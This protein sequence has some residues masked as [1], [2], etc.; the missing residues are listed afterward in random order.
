M[1]NDY[2]Q[3]SGVPAYGSQASSTQLRA[4]L[5]NIQDAFDKLPNLSGA[6][7][8]LVGVK[9]DGSGLEAKPILML[10]D[11]RPWFGAGILAWGDSQF[12][13]LKAGPHPSFVVDFATGNVT[14]AAALAQTPTRSTVASGSTITLTNFTSHLLYDQ[15][16][17]A[18]L[19]VN[20][21]PSD[22]V[23]GQNI[24]IATRSAITVLTL[25]GGT[26]YG[27][28]SSLDA[29]GFASFIYSAAAAAWFRKG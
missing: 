14:L 8:L 2:Y 20:L 16:F 5:R 24:T 6:E 12:D 9:A 25:G 22:L 7:G 26:I 13:S 10:A 21:P 28:P 29:G 17:P 4:E 1:S 23:D 15:P 18:T 11:G 19:A 3:H 27:A